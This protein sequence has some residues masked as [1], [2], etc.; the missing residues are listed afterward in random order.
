MQS[1]PG[2]RAHEIM[3]LKIKVSPYKEFLC[4]AIGELD[5]NSRIRKRLQEL[6]PM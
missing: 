4:Q 3:T 2:S 5:Q 6:I 1:P